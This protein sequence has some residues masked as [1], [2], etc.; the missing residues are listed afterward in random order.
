MTALIC[1]KPQGEY[2]LV[3]GH[4]SAS[5]YLHVGYEDQVFPDGNNRKRSRITMLVRKV[6]IRCDMHVT[7]TR[8]HVVKAEFKC[9][10]CTNTHIHAHAR[11]RAHKYTYMHIYTHIHT[12]KLE[13][14]C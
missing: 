13:I 6:S 2:L 1:S 10:T 12:Y 5:R 3:C 14:S 4:V 11:I 9:T 8:T 7:N